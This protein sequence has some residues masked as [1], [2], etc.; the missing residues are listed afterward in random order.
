MGAREPIGRDLAGRRPDAPPRAPRQA[1][2]NDAPPR[3]N[4][5]EGEKPDLPKGVR[6]EIMRILG[7]GRKNDDVALALSIGSAAIEQDRIDVALECLAWAKHEAPRVASVREAYGVALYL[8]ERYSEALTELQA[9]RRLTGRIDQN[10]VIA[11]CLRALGRDLDQIADAA[12]NL[13]ADAQAPEDRRAEAA[14]VWAAAV[15]DNGDIGAARSILRS[16]LERRRS[17]D[18]EHDLRVRYLAA[19]LAERANDDAELV[20][21]LEQILAVDETFLDVAERLDGARARGLG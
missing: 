11:D 5:P 3:P 8:G 21:Q 4:L 19:D 18:A 17:G 13:V 16:F 20:R 15:A 6:N 1:S 2:S 10:H 7:K 14:I 12:E 9:Y